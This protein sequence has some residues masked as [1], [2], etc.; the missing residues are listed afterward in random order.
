MQPALRSP[1][2]PESTIEEDLSTAIRDQ[3]SGRLE[4]PAQIYQRI[5]ARHADHGDALHLL[6]VVALQKG[7]P[8]RAVGLIGRAVAVNPS[9]AAF[10]CNLAEANR[11][12]GQLDRAAGCSQLALR[13][14]PDYPE[15]ANHWGLILLAQGKG[16]AAVAQFREALPIRPDAPMVHNNLGNALRLEGDKGGGWPAFVRPCSRAPTCDEL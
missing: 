15:A 16:Q 9:A 7:N 14:H 10:H 13:L 11:A 4:Q 2:P 5:L 12:L 3:Q 8:H 6:G 1:D